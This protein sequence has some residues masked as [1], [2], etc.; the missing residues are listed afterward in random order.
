MF[1]F[2]FAGKYTIIEPK[3]KPLNINKMN[4]LFAFFYQSLL[5]EQR[6]PFALFALKKNRNQN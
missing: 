3:D 5:C 6:V 1:V 4:C 2:L